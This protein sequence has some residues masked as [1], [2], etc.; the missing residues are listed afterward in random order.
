MDIESI[1]RINREALRA[2][3]AAEGGSYEK[4]DNQ[5]MMM[6]AVAVAVAALAYFVM[7][8]Y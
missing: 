6:Y 8:K 7:Q 2:A 3:Q 4:V 1:K 5:Q